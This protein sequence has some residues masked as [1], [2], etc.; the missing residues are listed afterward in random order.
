[1]N[2]VIFKI[3]TILCMCLAFT[4]FSLAFAPAFV[5]AAEKTVVFVA[6][7]DSHGF[8]SHEHGGGCRYLAATLEKGLPGIKTRVHAGGW[9]K[10]SSIFDGA[11]AVV[12]Y[13]DGGGGHPVNRHLEEVDKLMKKGIGLACIHYAVEVPKG[14]SGNFFLDWTGGYFETHWSV[15]PHWIA[16]FKK[17][18]KHPITSGVKPFKINDEWY[19]HMRFRDKLEGVTPILSAVAPESTMRRRN[20]A[21]SGNAAVRASVAKGDLQ[22][23][24]WARERPDGGRGFGFT[25]GHVHWNWG[26][27]NFRKLVLNAIAWVAKAEVPGAGVPSANPSKDEL[28]AAIK[29]KKVAKKAGKLAPG[30]PGVKPV[31]KS[32]V[33][34]SRTPGCSIKV[35][36]DIRGAKEL[37][38]VASDGGNGFSC[39]W[40]DWGEPRL[41]GPKGEKKL[42]ELKWS[43]ASS[44]FGNVKVNANCNGQAMRMGGRDVPYGL[45]THANSAIAYKLPPGYE[46]FRARAGLDNGGTDQ[47]ACGHNSSVQ[48]MVYTG[49]P[50]SAVLTSI[51]GGG[52][53]GGGADSREPG[54]ALAGL[55]V[56]ADLDATLFASEPAIVSP[57]NLDIDHRGRIW[58]CEVVNYRR[59][60]GRRPEG[61]RIVILEDTNG[62]GVS[63]TSKVFYQGRDID[64]AMGIVVLGNKVIVSCAPNV[65][66]FHDDD[67]DDKSDRKEVLF[68]KTGQPQHDH[69]THSI[70]FGPDGK[71][72]WNV[73]NTGRH[74]HDA[75]GTIITDIDGKEVRDNGK[76]Y[77]GGMVFRCNADG[78]EFEVLG[79]NFRNNYEATVDSLGA[80]WQS[81]NDDDGNRGV[82]INY[83]MEFGNYGYRDEMTGAGWRSN[84]VGIEKEIPRRHWHLNDPGVVP[85][86]LQT[87][88]GS[89]TGITVYEGR[90]LPKI[91]WDQVIHCDAGPNVCRAY[92]VKKTGAGYSAESVDILKGSRD[93]WFRPA[94]VSVA[95]D[96]SLFVTD[97]YDPGVGGHG[98]RD[99]GRG[100]IFRVAPPKTKYK[101]PSFDFKTA[102]GAVEALKNPNYAVRYLAWTALHGM[103]IKA[104][105]AL[106]GL[107]GSDNVR[108][109][110]RAL[111]LL[112]KTEGRG[113]HYVELASGDKE[114]DI[115]VVSVR[116]ARQ[117]KQDLIPL[118][119]KLVSDSSAAVRREC[120]LALRREKS[121]KAPALWA[122]LA[123]AHDG[124]DR[125]YL[126]ALGIS[127]ANRW[128][129]Y[130]GAWLAGQ[131]GKA[132]SAASRNDVVWRSRAKAT[133]DQLASILGGK[134]E[135]NEVPRYLRAFDFLSGPEKDG[136]LIAL[137]FGAG[138]DASPAR[139]LVA[140]EALKRLGNFD[141]KK[142]AK[143]SKALDG[144]LERSKG[145]PQFVDLVNRFNMTAKYPDLLEM[146]IADP[147]G[148]AGVDAIRIL[149]GKNATE[150]VSKALDGGDDK[151]VASIVEVLSNSGENRAAGILASVVTDDDRSMELR[152]KA[153]KGLARSENGGRQ[154]V[155]M[156][157]KDELDP[158]LRASAALDLHRSRAKDV[159]S[160]AAKLFP[161]PKT[162]SNRLLPSIAKLLGARGN[163]ERGAVVFAKTGTCGNCHKVN[164]VGKEV[165]PDMSEIGGKLTKEALLESIL[166]PS[167]A[168]GQNFETYVV[169]L[170]NGETHSGILISQT[171]AEVVIRGADALNKKFAKAKV[172]ALKK[173]K[174]S[175]MPA[176]LQKQMSA[177]ELVDVVAY[178]ATLK[179]AKK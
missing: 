132:S 23:V 46:R 158:G 134:L 93:R 52:G 47:G 135:K 26:D 95:P 168:I 142:D 63:D 19:F 37:Y 71:F 4:F 7:R 103:G 123:A 6:G 167:A 139:L 60:N 16:D 2:I 147:A 145:T 101:V 117:L 8:G 49:N 178:M 90:L 57:T 149:L 84:R 102:A 99:L 111:W 165:G 89:P 140:Q 1:M 5:A 172:L 31:F 133:P 107:Y 104:E 39:D 65:F 92:P 61:D 67:G 105:K 128:D 146:A 85:N 75:K 91:F 45:G 138:K 34:T 169:V 81:D 136:A 137:A 18:P 98:M 144:L 156:A 44:G 164:G 10:D 55:D 11:D 112:G 129:E 96:G 141:P 21:H 119:T 150:L 171:A 131:A 73:G 38:L 76:P 121:D 28:I 42:T 114:E 116:L 56:H 155:K 48:F 177:Q 62:D 173:D 64:S 33:V 36:V 94:D 24:A 152:R 161:L 126:E 50:G 160:A 77:F 166:F 9:P 30:K 113:A 115:R 51:G 162:K 175:L 143:Y 110:A 179:K 159:R 74:V 14:K 97:W 43:S 78:S 41:V 59:N 25:G 32:P 12:L 53:G 118:L 68:T 27:E 35:D 153:V 174:L 80:V 127:A 154:L 72:Y 40:A 124:E 157:Q 87:G 170:K 100:R 86:L 88:A 66:V 125:W 120:A 163:V 3:R 130:F 69:S 109:R 15:N 13:M 176:D 70:V 108:H 20:G 79:H 22:H 148:Q 122:K 17:L 82:R 58:I 54:D 106:L 151:K 29:G 83:V